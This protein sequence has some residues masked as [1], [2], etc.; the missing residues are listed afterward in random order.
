MIIYPPLASKRSTWWLTGWATQQT[1][2]SPVSRHAIVSARREHNID[3]ATCEENSI[4]IATEF[5]N[6]ANLLSMQGF[7][8]LIY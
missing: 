3:I 5:F 2:I 4:V 7:N 1:R 6:M 8:F